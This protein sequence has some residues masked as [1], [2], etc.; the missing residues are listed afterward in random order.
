MDPNVGNPRP[1]K[2]SRRDFLNRSVA[3]ALGVSISGTLALTRSAYAAGS[4]V[5]KL[6][7]I[8]CGGRG[9]GAAVQALQNKATK[10]VKL[11]AMAD[12]FQDRL[13]G[14]LK[15]IQTKCGDQVDVPP[16]RQFVGFDCHEKALEAGVDMVLLCTPPGFRRRT[17][18]TTFCSAMRFQCT[19]P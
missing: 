17:A 9:T 7:L 12:A 11:V 19:K 6:A 4:D 15:R 2:A 13:E 16:E 14:A 1:G 10:G 3:G 18:P 8:G 5:I